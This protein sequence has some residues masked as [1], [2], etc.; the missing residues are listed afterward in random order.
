MITSREYEGAAP[1]YDTQTQSYT[2]PYRD[3]S[4]VDNTG[5]RDYVSNLK[6]LMDERF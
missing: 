1:G 5:V 4:K 2:F 3:K 6:D